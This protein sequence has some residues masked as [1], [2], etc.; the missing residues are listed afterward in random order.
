MPVSA[1]NSPMLLNLE[2]ASGFA[3]GIRIMFLKL[4]S[5]NSFSTMLVAFQHYCISE[6]TKNKQHL[7]DNFPPAVSFAFDKSCYFLFSYISCISNCF[8]FFSSCCCF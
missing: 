6:F 3:V 4:L 8:E 7:R 1:G 2:K 5:I